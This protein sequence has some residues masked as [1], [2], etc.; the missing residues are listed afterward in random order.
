MVDTSKVC[1]LM[2]DESSGVLGAICSKLMFSAAKSFC[3]RTATILISFFEE[4]GKLV[5]L[6]ERAYKEEFLV[7]DYDLNDLQDSSAFMILFYV[8]SIDYIYE[9]LQEVTQ[10]LV[11]PELL[12]TINV[13][14]L[15]E[16]ISTGAGTDAMQVFNSVLSLGLCIT[17]CVEKLAVVEWPVSLKCIFQSIHDVI[18]SKYPDDFHQRFSVFVQH[19]IYRTLSSFLMNRV[20][21]RHA[22]PTSFVDKYFDTLS[23]IGETFGKLVRSQ[24]ETYILSLRGLIGNNTK[25]HSKLVESILTLDDQKKQEFYNQRTKYNGTVDQLVALVKPN[26]I[27]IMERLKPAVT[28]KF[29]K[30]FGLMDASNDDYFVYHEAVFSLETMTRKY[31]EFLQALLQEASNKE[32]EYNRVRREY[33][34]L[35]DEMTKKREMNAQLLERVREI[36][37]EEAAEMFIR[38]MEP[39]V[40]L[41]EKEHV[42]IKVV[43]PKK[44]RRSIKDGVSKLFNLGRNPASVESSPRRPLSERSM[45]PSVSRRN[46]S[47]RRRDASCSSRFCVNRDESSECRSVKSCSGVSSPSIVRR[48]SSVLE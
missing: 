42:S 28:L 45:T 47:D 6:F 10:T 34:Q 13:T 30:A 39:P 5:D 7:K 35:R 1:E 25:E 16:S 33:E 22:H 36:S 41:T 9:P 4:H 37:G 8:Y 18:K 14:A 23:F 3:T 21:L 19:I 12:D 43:K 46:S 38:P 26:A 17:N 48:P 32:A 40:I 20:I 15:K 44:L 11:N 24:N 27:P 2:F 31:S 29:S